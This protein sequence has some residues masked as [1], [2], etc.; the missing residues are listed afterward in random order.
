MICK[1]KNSYQSAV[2]RKK[3]VLIVYALGFK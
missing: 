1:E 3:H 2:T